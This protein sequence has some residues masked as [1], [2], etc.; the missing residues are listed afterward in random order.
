[1][2]VQ[3]QLRHRDM[4]HILRDMLGVNAFV[5]ISIPLKTKKQK[6]TKKKKKKKTKKKKEK[7]TLIAVGIVVFQCFQKCLTLAEE[8]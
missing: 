6:K 5:L 3:S 7:R 2:I 4:R 8:S 1:M